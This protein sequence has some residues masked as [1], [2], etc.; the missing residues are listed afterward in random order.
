[1][2]KNSR[3]SHPIARSTKT[4]PVGPRRDRPDL[5]DDDPRARAPAVPKVHHEEPH[6]DDGRP[7]RG[8]LVIKVINVPSQDDG[9]DEVAQ[10]HADG[11]DAEDGLAAEAIDPKD[12]RDGR[13]EHDDS[14]HACSEK[15]RGVFAKA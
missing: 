4:D 3:G 5:C 12:G 13:D 14:D 7:A 9:N 6:H 15:T 11:T 10:G 8:L 2:L 1:M